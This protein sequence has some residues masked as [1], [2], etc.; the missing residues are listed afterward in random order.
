M[1][2]VAIGVVLQQ[3]SRENYTSDRI[4]DMISAISFPFDSFRLTEFNNDFK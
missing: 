4:R 3:A 2:I 1:I